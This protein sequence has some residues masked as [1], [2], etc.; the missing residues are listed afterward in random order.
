MN[1]TQSKAEPRTAKARRTREAIL[2]A[3]LELMQEVGYERATMRAIA[4]R[5]Q[6]SIGNAYYY[7][8]SKEDLVQAFYARTHAEHLVVARPRIAAARG[9]RQRL[10][11]TMSA[12]L[13]T[14]EPYHPFAGVLFR[15]AADPNSPLNPFSEESAPVREEATQLFREVVLGAGLRLPKDLAA[16]LPELLWT[17][18]MGVILYWVHDTSEGRCKSWRLMEQSTALI[19]S[20]VRLSSLPL[21]APLRRK[22]LQLVRELAEVEG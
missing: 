19:A 15:T 10:L 11:A 2:G 21:L 6:V 9:L 8:R 4:E 14:I 12:K 5:A 18:H 20:A 3:A 22:A 16:E 13:E 7:F 17:W 1:Q